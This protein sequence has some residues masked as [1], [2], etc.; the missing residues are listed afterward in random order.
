MLVDLVS[1]ARSVPSTRRRSW[2]WIMSPSKTVFQKSLWLWS[3]ELWFFQ[4]AP[5]L[6]WLE[7]QRPQILRQQQPQQNMCLISRLVTLLRQVLLGW[8]AYATGIEQ[9]VL[10]PQHC[11]SHHTMCDYQQRQKSAAT[12]TAAKE[13]CSS[14][15]SWKPYTSLLLRCASCPLEVTRIWAPFSKIQVV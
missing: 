5:C 10:Q 15:H 13:I 8:Y 7:S 2:K 1:S 3:T 12:K 6:T 11:V 9:G 14:K 4:G